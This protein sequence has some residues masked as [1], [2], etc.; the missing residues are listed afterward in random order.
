MNTQPEPAEVDLNQDIN[1]WPGSPLST[2]HDFGP[3]QHAV[4]TE[5]Y[6]QDE[7]YIV[8]FELPGV[9]VKNINVTIEG[10]ELTVHAE[11]PGSSSGKDH[12][13]FRYGE[14]TSHVTLPSGM[15][16]SDV[17]ADYVNGILA[18]TVCFE[19]KAKHAA[20]KVPVRVARVP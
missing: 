1:D 6:P 5:H 4:K 20:H 2:I 11:R 18:V 7:H 3:V 16:D 9:E 13:E 17:M 15:D 19:D 8:R 10:R 14:F 12:S